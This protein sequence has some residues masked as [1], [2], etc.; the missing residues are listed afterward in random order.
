MF[1][2]NKYAWVLLVLTLV[3]G[4]CANSLKE[5]SL[6]SASADDVEL[7]REHLAHINDLSVT[8]TG[9]I[10]YYVWVEEGF[11]WNTSSIKSSSY[12]WSCETMIQFLE[13]GFVIKMGFKGKGGREEHYDLAK[14]Q[15]DS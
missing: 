15:A 4:G 14:C 10:T 7:A 12:E 5:V 2:M 1:L 13:A 3:I 9:Y 8:D 11:V 6:P